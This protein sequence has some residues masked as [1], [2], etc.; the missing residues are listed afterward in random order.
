MASRA[1]DSSGNDFSLLA[2]IVGRDAAESFITFFRAQQQ[3][4]ELAQY[5]DEELSRFSISRRYQI[6]QQCL[7]FSKENEKEARA[8]VHRLG[9]EYEAWFRYMLERKKKAGLK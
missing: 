7:Y 8:L 5:S 3:I 2:P 9:A 6:A 4:N 1:L